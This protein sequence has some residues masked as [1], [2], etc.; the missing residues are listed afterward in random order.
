MGGNGI[1]EKMRD[2]LGRLIPSRDNGEIE[3]LR[4]EVKLLQGKN[5]QYR[6]RSK[7]IFG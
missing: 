6:K 2:L 3:A 7:T 5:R 1:L 4:T